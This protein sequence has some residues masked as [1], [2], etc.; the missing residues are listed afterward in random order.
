VEQGIIH[1]PALMIA[2]MAVSILAQGFWFP[3][4]NLILSADRQSTYTI[5]FVVLA[6]LAMPVTYFLSPVMGS[7]AP[8]LAMALSDV[9]MLVL[10]MALV[11]RHLVGLD[12]V[13]AAGPLA[14]EGC[15]GSPPGRAPLVAAAQAG[16][17]AIQRIVTIGGRGNGDGALALGH[18]LRAALQAHRH[19]AHHCGHIHA[20]KPCGQVEGAVVAAHRDGHIGGRAQPQHNVDHIGQ[21]RGAHITPGIPARGVLRVEDLIALEHDKAVA[22]NCGRAPP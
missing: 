13:L 22:R 17:T 18:H 11:Q 5:P 7:A 10:V 3:L 9:V 21:R 19:R 14:R 4:S 15:A 12:K 1:A 6:L 16:K 8:A 2:I 20:L